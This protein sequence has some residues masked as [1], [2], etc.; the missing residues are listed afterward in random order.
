MGVGYLMLLQVHHISSSRKVAYQITRLLVTGDTVGLFWTDVGFWRPTTSPSLVSRPESLSAGS[1]RSLHSTLA[2]P[3]PQLPA[4]W[5]AVRLSRCVRKPIKS[6][7]PTRGTRPSFPKGWAS[8]L[9]GTFDTRSV[10]SRPP[11]TY[12]SS[13]LQLLF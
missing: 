4:R 12:F 5:L 9:A 7:P 6:C 10:E 11:P 2:Y 3:S 1:G 8:Q 13:C